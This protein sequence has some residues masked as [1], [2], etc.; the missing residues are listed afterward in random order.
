MGR[1]H[2]CPHPAL[3]AVLALRPP[4]AKHA[5]NSKK[6]GLTPQQRKERYAWI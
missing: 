5:D 3:S 4:Q 6:D 2:A 1:L